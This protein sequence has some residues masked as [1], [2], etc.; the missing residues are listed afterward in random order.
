MRIVSQRLLNIL[1]FY[2]KRVVAMALWPFIILK[3][4]ATK[5]NQV[6]INHEKI[7]HRQQ[8]ELLIIPYYLWYFL[9]YWAGM[10]NNGFKH[11]QAYMAISF[12]REAFAHQLD[13]NYLQKRKWLSSWVFFKGRFRK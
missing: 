13:L 5:N 9:E 3:D 12:E 1:T 2:N 10:F 6:V 8:L 11:H 4:Q 7:H